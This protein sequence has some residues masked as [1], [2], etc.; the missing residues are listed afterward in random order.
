M[1]KFNLIQNY[2][3]FIIIYLFSLNKI[4][5]QDF[6]SYVIYI[7]T[8][9]IIL[10]RFC[11]IYISSI[12]FFRY[13][14]LNHMIKKTHS[15][16]MKVHYKIDEYMTHLNLYTFNEIICFNQLI[17][18]LKIIEKEFIY[19]FIKYEIYKM[20]SKNMCI[21]YYIHRKSISNYKI[22]SKWDNLRVFEYFHLHV[23]F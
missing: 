17:T 16:S 7:L 6:H 11:E 21:Y 3:R 22:S 19:N 14:K 4:S 15:I 12:D 9:K 13:Y 10:Y 8:F 1:K 5:F 23:L 20:I 18:E 2:N